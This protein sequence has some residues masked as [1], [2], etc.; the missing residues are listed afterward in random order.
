MTKKRAKKKDE[1]PVI[2]SSVSGAKPPPVEISEPEVSV[3]IESEGQVSYEVSFVQ[4]PVES[5]TAKIESDLQ[6]LESTTRDASV[7]GE[8]IHL[9][10]EEIIA[11]TDISTNEI[12]RS[13]RSIVTENTEDNTDEIIKNDTAVVTDSSQIADSSV[14][15]VIELLNCKEIKCS[16]SQSNCSDTTEII[17]VEHVSLSEGQVFKSFKEFKCKFD[18]WCAQNNHPMKTDSCKKKTEDKSLCQSDFPFQQIRFTCK[19]SG[20]PRIRGQGKRPV[21]AYL[22][23]E[24]PMVLRLKLDHNVCIHAYLSSEISI[25]FECK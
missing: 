4:E 18:A 9:E 15:D 13:D 22:P 12:T 21:Q 23:C 11:E 10:L 25:C 8:P 7:D 19:H 16:L 24:C 20:K 1:R 6:E 14:D 3:N 5:N 2:D 17:T